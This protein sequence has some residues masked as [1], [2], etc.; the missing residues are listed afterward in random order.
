[1]PQILDLVMFLDLK[2]VESG[3]KAF[4]YEEYILKISK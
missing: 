3:K 1:M 2:F 4:E